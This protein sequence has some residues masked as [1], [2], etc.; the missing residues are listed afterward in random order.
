MK[1]KSVTPL[2]PELVSKDFEKLVKHR[3][4]SLLNLEGEVHIL[5]E[6][7]RHKEEILQNVT[8]AWNQL[9]SMCKIEYEE[10]PVIEEIKGDKD[11]NI[12][13]INPSDRRNN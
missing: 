4:E 11:I 1:I 2:F 6:R 8:A 10:E 3:Y 9:E 12:A 7:L 13:I 5:R